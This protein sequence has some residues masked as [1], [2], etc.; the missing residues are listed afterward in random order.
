MIQVVGNAIRSVG[1]WGNMVARM[2]KALTESQTF[3]CIVQVIDS[4]SQRVDRTL[5]AASTDKQR[6]MSWRERSAAKKHGWGACYSLGRVFAGMAS[7]PDSLM[8]QQSL[9]HAVRNLVRCTQ[10]EQTLLLSEKV[11]LAAMTSLRVM[12]PCQLDAISG[13]HG[14]VGEAIV[15]CCVVLFSDVCNVKF[16]QEG[17]QLLRHLLSCASILDATF[18]VKHDDVTKSMLESLYGWMVEHGME[19]RAFEIFA[20]AFQRPILSSNKNDISLEQR[21]ASRAMSQYKKA[22]MISLT[23]ADDDNDEL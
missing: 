9:L 4:L 14:V 22:Q 6:E 15:G 19:G 16:Q 1:H 20:L 13:K 8:D 5:A 21:F 18:V 10:R 7:W 12:K 23:S 2:S 3:R 17:N 11:V